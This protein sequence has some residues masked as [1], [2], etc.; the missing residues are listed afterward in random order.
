MSTGSHAPAVKG[1]RWLAALVPAA[2]VSAVW[3]PVAL[4]GGSGLN[5]PGGWAALA[6]EAAVRLLV[7]LLLARAAR[8]TSGDQRTLLLGAT[9]ANALLG[10]AAVSFRW[11]WFATDNALPIADFSQFAGYLTLITTMLILQARQFPGSARWI[12]WTE[13]LTLGLSAGLLAWHFVVR[14]NYQYSTFGATLGPTLELLYP[15]L[16][17]LLLVLALDTARHHL[18]GTSRASWLWAVLTCVAGDATLSVD[19]YLVASPTMNLIGDVIGTSTAVGFAALAAQS[20]R[21]EVIVSAEVAPLPIAQQSLTPMS[22]GAG[23]VVVLAAAAA[24][25]SE[26]AGHGQDGLF[27]L[28]GLSVIAAIRFTRLVL[29]NRERGAEAARIRR[30][31]EREVA[32]RTAQLAQL[33]DA[34][35]RLV[36]TLSHELRSPLNAIL[37]LTHL[38]TARDD[39]TP[40]QRET[41]GRIQQHSRHLVSLSENVLTMARIEAGHEVL[42]H[43]PFDLEDVLVQ[44]GDVLQRDAGAKGLRVA[45]ERPVDLP[46]QLVGDQTRLTQLF[47]N[48]ISNAIK[49]TTRGGITLRLS[50]APAGDRIELTGEVTDSG[51]GI[52]AEDQARLFRRFQQLGGQEGPEPGAGLGLAICRWIAEQMDG[53]VGVRSTPGSGSTFW[54]RV[55]LECQPVREPRATAPVEGA[56]PSSRRFRRGARVLVVDDMPVNRE[57]A[58]E[59]LTAV[60]MEVVEADGGRAAVRLAL[61]QPFDAVL[62]DLRMP[63]LDGYAATMAIRRDDRG[64]TVPIIAMTAVAADE[65]G[66]RS[67]AV[68]M[69][70][71]LEKPFEPDT[72]LDVILRWTGADEQSSVSSV[73]W[74]RVPTPHESPP[75]DVPGLD[76]AAGL[77]RVMGNQRLYSAL[78]AEFV[79]SHGQA[80]AEIDACLLGGDLGA[81]QRIAHTL[82]GAAGG[83]GATEVHAAATA[84]DELLRRREAD[85]ASR[86]ADDL[87]LGLATLVEALQEHLRG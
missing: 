17:A 34:R 51:V 41:L 14:G 10:A 68:G 21:G 63:D 25:V 2:I 8:R 13:S 78:L 58:R 32:A 57:I 70:D 52:G 86:A 33:T 36:A 83:I 82:R 60:G 7:T 6:V 66:G 39:V 26:L 80:A 1:D 69:S 76:S 35:T 19:A 85:A 9:V 53:T 81:A 87:R 22:L 47:L 54:F 62:M 67:L 71:R 29:L 5:S 56:M 31:L 65:D 16:D 75:P 24:I 55:R 73:R 43:A 15:I 46:R 40:V 27:W 28:V 3:M 38:L 48:Y 61:S 20:S 74:P 50:A 49:A 44:V 59:V 18:R 77:R 30:E 12:A 84:L 23:V 79:H 4:R 37:G 64:R 45:I 72:L 42:R 11:Q